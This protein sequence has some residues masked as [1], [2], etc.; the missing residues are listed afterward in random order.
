MIF[1]VPEKKSKRGNL[2]HQKEKE[3][4]ILSDEEK[5]VTHGEVKF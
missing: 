3:I 4:G 1:I 2:Q 5:N